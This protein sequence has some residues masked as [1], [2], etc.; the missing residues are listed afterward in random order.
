M[1]EITQTIEECVKL[2]LLCPEG[3]EVDIVF[4]NEVQT[5]LAD[6]VTPANPHVSWTCRYAEL[7]ESEIT[8]GE[9]CKG[10]DWS[11]W[12]AS[13]SWCTQATSFSTLSFYS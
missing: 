11:I 1:S 10:F 8:V 12:A 9:D 7:L 13:L 6:E 3:W 2:D 5:G 4:E